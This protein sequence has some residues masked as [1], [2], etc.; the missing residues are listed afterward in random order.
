MEISPFD[1]DATA[2]LSLLP[3]APHSSDPALI[4]SWLEGKCWHKG[5]FGI[6]TDWHP[7]PQELLMI[8]AEIEQDRA[9]APAGT[10]GYDFAV[11]AEGADALAD[12]AFAWLESAC[13]EAGIVLDP[14]T[15]DPE[16]VQRYQVLHQDPWKFE[17]ESKRRSDAEKEAIRDAYYRA[18]PATKEEMDL[19]RALTK[20]IRDVNQS[21][22]VNDPD[23]HL[24]DLARTVLGLERHGP[25]AVGKASGLELLLRASA[26]AGLVRTGLVASPEL[27]LAIRQAVALADLY[28]ADLREEL[29]EEPSSIV[30]Y[31]GMLSPEHRIAV[32]DMLVRASII[33]LDWKAGLPI[34]AL[35]EAMIEMRLAQ[36][37]RLSDQPVPRGFTAAFIANPNLALADLLEEVGG[38]AKNQPS[39]AA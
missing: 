17:I 35:K 23:H 34:Q 7:D 36:A 2:W 20:A 22:D 16:L 8:R 3:P 21:F 11:Y 12:E 19:S 15:A 28:T 18:F 27:E 39:F 4:R 38:S 29:G 33:A 31:R 9:A 1:R 30:D 32:E 13:N 25:A 24:T 10:A 26:G 14:P 5:A 6:E 37:W